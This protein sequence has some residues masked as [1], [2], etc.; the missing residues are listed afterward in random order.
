MTRNISLPTAPN[1]D[2]IMRDVTECYPSRVQTAATSTSS[3]TMTENDVALRFS[4]E[5]FSWDMFHIGVPFG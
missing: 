1:K 2:L 4:H 3:P 5:R